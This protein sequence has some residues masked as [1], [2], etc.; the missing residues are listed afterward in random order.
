LIGG[1]R[2]K[3]YRWKVRS[4]AFVNVYAAPTMLI[5]EKVADVPAVIG[6]IDMCIGET[7]K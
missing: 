5:G 2:D 3:P 7:D 1:G 4:P 6:S